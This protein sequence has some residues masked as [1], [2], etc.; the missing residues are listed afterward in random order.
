MIEK[1][2]IDSDIDINLIYISVTFII[3]VYLHRHQKRI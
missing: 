3:R 1:I 2:N